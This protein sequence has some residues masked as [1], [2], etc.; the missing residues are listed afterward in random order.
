MKKMAIVLVSL[1]AAFSFAEQCYFQTRRTSYDSGTSVKKISCQTVKNVMQ[2]VYF[3]S[4]SDNYTRYFGRQI[5]KE[6]N[7]IVE[8][9]GT[10]IISKFYYALGEYRYYGQI[11]YRGGNVVSCQTTTSTG[12]C[13]QTEYTDF[14]YY[15]TEFLG[16][17]ARKNAN[18]E[19][20]SFSAVGKSA[21]KKGG[22]FFRDSRDGTVYKTVKIGDQVWMAENLTYRGYFLRG[23]TLLHVPEYGK[24]TMFYTWS[25]AMEACPDGWRLP[26]V[27][28]WK[29]LFEFVSGS[30]N[31]YSNGKATRVLKCK[32]GWGLP[33]DGGNGTDDYGFC[34]SPVG[35]VFYDGTLMNVGGSASFWTSRSGYAVAFPM[36]NDY[37]GVE[38]FSEDYGFS[39][40][41]IKDY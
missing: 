9:D 8:N 36:A 29:E 7:L 32:E 26:S 30:D 14:G 20:Q 35:L 23:R 39:V 11:I 1:M 3:Y 31:I 28:N 40:R 24:G 5:G 13:D 2:D 33:R 27:S 15:F 16:S 19:G 6:G 25:A 41:C 18:K 17:P 38:P 12:Y 10:F 4:G 21:R 22:N 34:V 37:G